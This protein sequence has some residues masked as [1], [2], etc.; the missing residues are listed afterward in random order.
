MDIAKYEAQ[1]MGGKINTVQKDI[2]ALKKVRILE[3]PLE[4]RL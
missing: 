2:G 3:K 1:Q 4:S